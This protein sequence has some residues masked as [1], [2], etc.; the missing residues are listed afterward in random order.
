M[1]DRK[2]LYY[3][4]VKLE[5]GFTK[6]VSSDSQRLMGLSIIVVII[7]LQIIVVALLIKVI[8]LKIIFI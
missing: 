8:F 7:L 5:A 3:S 6:V 1:T 4:V 2:I